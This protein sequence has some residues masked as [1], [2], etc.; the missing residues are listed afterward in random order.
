VIQR[1]IV[2]N[3]KGQEN[4]VQP[5]NLMREKIEGLFYGKFCILGGA[6]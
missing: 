5:F 3:I 4:W 2:S 1:A 6:E